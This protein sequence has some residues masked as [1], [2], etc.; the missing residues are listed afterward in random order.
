MVIPIILRYQLV[1]TKIVQRDEKKFKLSFINMD[2]GSR[3]RQLRKAKGIEPKR[4]AIESGIKWEDLRAFENNKNPHPSVDRIMKF[5]TPLNVS[6]AEF[7]ASETEVPTEFRK[8]GRP[9]VDLDDTESDF[10]DI[11]V[12]VN[13]CPEDRLTHAALTSNMLLFRESHRRY[14]ES[15]AEKDRSGPTNVLVKI[16]APKG[17]AKNG[18]KKRAVHGKTFAVTG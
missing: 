8:E 13:R 14:L 2:I 4:F 15:E 7:F 16:S 5:I 17:R 9:I 6:L 12:K 11:L 18:Q 10:L 3:F 1:S